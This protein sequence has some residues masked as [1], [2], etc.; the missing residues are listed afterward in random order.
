MGEIEIELIECLLKT[1]YR[2]KTPNRNEKWN[3]DR[4][5]FVCPFD[6]RRHTCWTEEKAREIIENSIIQKYMIG[7]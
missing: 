4:W 3:V 7:D 5:V 6:G 2:P 1:A